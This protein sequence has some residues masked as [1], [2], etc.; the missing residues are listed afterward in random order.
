VHAALF[1]DAGH[2]WTSRFD[3][4]DLKTSAG[5]ELSAN[6]VAGYSFP[7]TATVGAAWGRD[8]RTRDTGTMV[9]VR[10]GRAF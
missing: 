8:G 1:A 4:Q 5:A 10:V 3:F 7:F 6:V 2:A 9:Y